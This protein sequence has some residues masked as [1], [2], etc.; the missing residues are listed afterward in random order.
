MCFR[1]PLRQIWVFYWLNR[2]VRSSEVSPFNRLAV[3]VFRRSNAFWASP[4]SFSSLLTVWMAS[5]HCVMAVLMSFGWFFGLWRMSS[6]LMF[7]SGLV[8]SSARRI[9]DC[10][11]AVVAS[12]FAWVLA[13][14]SFPRSVAMY[15]SI[16]SLGSDRFS[17]SRWSI[18]LVAVS[19]FCCWVIILF[20][21]ASL[22]LFSC[23]AFIRSCLSVSSI[24]LILSWRAP[25]HGLMPSWRCSSSQPAPVCVSRFECVG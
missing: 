3:I 20:V 15:L 23:W 11:I 18:A 10:F 2:L 7:S 1:I 6:G 22:A 19:P 12:L 9:H 25:S 14:S 21:A 8:L 16:L 24:L 17:S 5:A 4:S 13:Y